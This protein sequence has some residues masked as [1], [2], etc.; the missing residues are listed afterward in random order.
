MKSMTPHGITGLEMVKRA[1]TISTPA[2]MHTIIASVSA[3]RV[4]KVSG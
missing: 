4:K 3:C 1:A 2:K